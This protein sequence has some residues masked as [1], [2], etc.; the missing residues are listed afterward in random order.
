MIDALRD[1]DDYY[2]LARL[3]DWP[4]ADLIRRDATL[5]GIVR[6]FIDRAERDCKIERLLDAARQLNA[7][8]EQLARIRAEQ[9]DVIDPAPSAGSSVTDEQRRR[10]ADALSTCFRDAEIASIADAADPDRRSVVWNRSRPGRADVDDLIT[11]AAGEGWVLPLLR[12]A[13]ERVPADAHLGALVA[14]VTGQAVVTTQ[15][16]EEAWRRALEQ[17]ML[18][19]GYFMINRAR[20][21]SSMGLMMPTIGNRILVVRGDGQSGL[22]HSKRLMYHLSEVCDGIS[23]AEVDLEVVSLRVGPNETLSPR[24]LAK[25][26]VRALRYDL[27]VAPEPSDRQW[28]AW[29]A[30]FGEEFALRA[31]DDPRRMFLVLDAFHKVPLTQPTTDLVEQLGTY[32]ATRVPSFRLVLLGFKGDL[33][34]SVRQARLLDETCALTERDIAEFFAQ[35]Y[36]DAN[37]PIDGQMLA[38]KVSFVLDGEESFPPGNLL[39]LSDRVERELPGRAS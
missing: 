31:N 25:Q 27:S 7:D 15:D 18:S 33:P 1:E 37:V 9:L 38:E 30:D 14:E 11:A 28:S 20:L 10:I 4:S 36:A 12:A 2:D 23:I 22:S 34:G 26:I 19:G 6:A 32:I 3:L 24:D 35:V 17:R 21:R 29:N 13:V 5:R 16:A 39:D 8:N